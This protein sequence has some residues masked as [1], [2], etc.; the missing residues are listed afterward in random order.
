MILTA[1]VMWAF[2][3][4]AAQVEPPFPQNA[5]SGWMMIVAGADRRL[6][7]SP[8]RPLVQTASPRRGWFAIY[9]ILAGTVA[10]WRGSTTRARCRWRCRRCRR[11]RCRWSAC[12]RA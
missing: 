2:H 9:N 5:P 12:S 6:R 11:C 4:A 1:A 7:H 8:T 10:H 3:G